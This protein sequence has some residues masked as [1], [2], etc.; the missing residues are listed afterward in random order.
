MTK[1]DD[2]PKKKVDRNAAVK[3]GM[4]VSGF[5]TRKLQS[6]MVVAYRVG[7]C[8][9]CSGV[10]HVSK[11]PGSRKERDKLFGAAR[12]GMKVVGLQVIDVTPPDDKKDYTGVRLS[13]RSSHATNKAD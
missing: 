3:L 8:R 13:A 12:V 6:A 10:L 4:L 9:K 11:F 1:C 7:D 2:K 5:F